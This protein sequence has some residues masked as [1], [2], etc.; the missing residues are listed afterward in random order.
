MA[1]RRTSVI[2]V[3]ANEDAARRAVAAA[4][5]GGADP[6]AIRI[7]DENDR[8]RE[9][10]AEMLDEVD[11]SVM[12]PG[13]IGPF[14]KEM[15]RAIVPLTIIFGLVGLVVAL[16]FAAIHFGGFPLWGRLLVLGVVGGAAGSV[17]GFQIG[18]SFGGRRPEERLATER[19][20]VVAIDDAPPPAIDVLKAMGPI[21]LDAFEEH[22]WP[23][24]PIVASDDV[25]AHGGLVPELEEHLRD[26]DLEG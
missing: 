3:F 22:G 5:Q 21:R 25:A 7:G 23:I 19:G 2:G 15:T 16:P 8:I 4:E 14:T 12:G 9:L 17:V 11:N 6:A 10:Q 24:G 13:S 26:R 18:G 20:V 1:Q